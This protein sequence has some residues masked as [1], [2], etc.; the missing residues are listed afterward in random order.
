MGEARRRKQAGTARAPK[1]SGRDL[2]A[3][4]YEGLALEPDDSTITGITLFPVGGGEPVC[5]DAATAKRRSG[6]KT[7]A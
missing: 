4:I 1:A 5:I 7:D 3:M 6:G 2:I